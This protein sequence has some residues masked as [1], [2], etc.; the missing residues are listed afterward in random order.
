M[1]HPALRIIAIPV[2]LWAALLGVIRVVV[3]PAE[4][5]G[6]GSP[7]QFRDTADLAARWLSINQY[8]DG[9]YVYEYDREVD[10]FSGAYNVVRHAGVTM[11]LYQVAGK[12]DDDEA[13]AAA[14]QG[15]AW[16][17]DNMVYHDDWGG[18]T[19]GSN[20][21][22]GSAA[23][24]TI[25]LAERR[26]LTGESTHDD[27]MKA[28]G[29]F[30]VSQQKENGGFF[31]KW[32]VET[33]TMDRVSTSAYYPGEALWALA[34][35]HEAFPDEGWDDAAWAA[36]DF[37]TLLRDDEEDVPFPPLND[38]WAAYGLAEMAEWGLEDHHTDYARRLAARFG[39]FIRFEAQKTDEGL[40]LQVR[41][42]SRR[43][44]AL[45][46]W[47]EGMAA[48]WRLSKSDERLADISDDILEQSSCGADLL[49]QRQVDSNEPPLEAGGWFIHGVT[50]MDDQQHAI[51]GLLYTADALEGRVK[52]EP[53]R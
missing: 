29:R 45:G 19:N 10:E 46:T 51:S 34:M 14:E 42:D 41:G 40:N 3:A 12:L 47:V 50:R 30:M 2:L 37:V 5:C 49:V 38:H 16:L 28:L 11:S 26:L 52:R 25:A 31:T 48:L 33:E 27:V 1:S 17:L 39:L 32:F 6:Q 8:D 15:T 9:S 18:P 53:D 36:A 21:K 43:S 20:V 22:V 4:L 13:F 23:L 24:M 35:L 7:E 44:S